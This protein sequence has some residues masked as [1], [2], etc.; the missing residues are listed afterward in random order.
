MFPS[1]N[2]YSAYAADYVKSCPTDDIISNLENNGTE[3]TDYLKTI[4]EEDSMFRYAPGKWTVREMIQHII[5]GERIFGYRACRIARMDK[6]P[7]ASFDENEF[8]KNSNGNARSLE[9]L[10]EEFAA[11]RKSTLLMY[12][13]YT[14]EMLKQRS[15]VSGN[16]VTVHAI[17]FIIPGHAWHHL[18]ILQTRYFPAEKMN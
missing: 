11:T 1:T 16:E 10:R 5:D 2:D 6:T 4:S 17:G 12:K 3:M 9:S 14:D 7:L 18:H 13:S 8:A 15:T